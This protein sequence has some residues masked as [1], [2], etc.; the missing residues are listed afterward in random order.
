M[1]TAD[2]TIIGGL[3]WRSFC[4]R[5]WP[6]LLDGRGDAGEGGGLKTESGEGRV[7]DER[8]RNSGWGYASQ[9]KPVRV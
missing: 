3:T 9:Q 6:S 7:G 8:V 2:Q 4:E 1:A 5:R